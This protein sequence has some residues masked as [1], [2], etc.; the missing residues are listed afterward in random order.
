MTFG[1]V[2]GWNIYIY[3]EGVSSNP[4]EEEQ[5]ICQLNILTL[6]GLLFRRMKST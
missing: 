3:T 4:V 6:W 1:R 5:N 2:P